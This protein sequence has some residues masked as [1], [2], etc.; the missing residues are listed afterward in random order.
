MLDRW[1]K[2][3]PALL[4]SSYASK[5]RPPWLGMEPPGKL[6]LEEEGSSLLPKCPVWKRVKWRQRLSV[7]AFSKQPPWSVLQQP[8]AVH[9]KNALLAVGRSI[10]LLSWP[11]SGTSQHPRQWAVESAP[12]IHCGSLFKGCGCPRMSQG[13]H[14]EPSSRWWDEKTSDETV[15]REQRGLT[16]MVPKH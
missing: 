15:S 10:R 7:P 11:E 2:D 4:P 5:E 16:G 14:S 13:A 3:R 9:G 1:G 6:N 12:Q 8:R